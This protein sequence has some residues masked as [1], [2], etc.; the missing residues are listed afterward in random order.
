MVGFS[1]VYRW[2]L[3]AS[4]KQYATIAVI[5]IRLDSDHCL[6]FVTNSLTHGSSGIFIYQIRI[7]TIKEA[8]GLAKALNRRAFVNVFFSP[9]VGCLLLDL[10]VLEMGKNGSGVTRMF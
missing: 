10:I 8:D 4:I 2:C 3:N 9:Y 5:F 6:A 1:L 7:Q